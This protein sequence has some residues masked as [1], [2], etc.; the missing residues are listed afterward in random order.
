MAV[1]RLRSSVSLPAFTIFEHEPGEIDDL[2]ITGEDKVLHAVISVGGFLGIGDKRVAVPYDQLQIQHDADDND[3]DVMYN[4]TKTELETMPA[5]SYRDG[6]L[7][8]R[9]RVQ[10]RMGEWTDRARDAVQN[11]TQDDT[12]TANSLNN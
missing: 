4:A 6:D 8:W 7:S 3:I 11:V 1:S 10:E 12:P 9:E 5:F 2:T